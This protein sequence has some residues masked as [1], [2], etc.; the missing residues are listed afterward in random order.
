MVDTEHKTDNRDQIINIRATRRQ[1]DLIDQA[2]KA[3]GKT[4]SDFMLE[5]AYREAADVLLDRRLFRLDLDAFARFNELLDS[6]P[7]P[8]ESLRRLLQTKPPWE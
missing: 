5:T 4:R 8:T 3:L 1:R 2:S 6:P 7:P